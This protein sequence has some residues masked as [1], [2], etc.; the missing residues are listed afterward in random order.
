MSGLVL[1]S[2][3]ERDYHGWRPLWDGYNAFYGR[4]DASALDERVTQQ[5]WGRFFDPRELVHAIVAERE[6]HLVGLVHFLYHR[7]TS[8]LADVCYLQDL[9]TD[10]HCRRQGVGRALIEQVLEHARA[11]G[12]SRVYWQTHADNAAGR[13]LYDQL[14]EHRGFI[15]YAHEL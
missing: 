8:R 4:S 12:A 11:V 10:P 2:L 3:E 9:F 6:G 15:V 5:T 1:R 7:S 14:A 13:A